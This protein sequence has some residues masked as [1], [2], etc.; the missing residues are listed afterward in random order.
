MVKAVELFGKEAQRTGT[1]WPVEVGKNSKVMVLNEDWGFIKPWVE[2]FVVGKK[3]SHLETLVHLNC[4]CRGK[5]N[6]VVDRTGGA[7]EACKTRP[8]KDVDTLAC[9]LTE[10][11]K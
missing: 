9:L 10:G 4:P 2:I 6:V 11:L 7:C 1:G 5:W 3:L 8:P